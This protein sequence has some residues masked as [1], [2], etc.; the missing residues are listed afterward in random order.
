MNART[1]FLIEPGKPTIVIQRLFD[2]PRRLVF[3][4]STRPEHLASWW[5]PRGSKLTQCKVDLRPGGA[6]RFV[7]RMPDGSEHG[8][9][10]VYKEIVAPSRLVQTFR[11]DGFPDAEALETATFEER[12]EKTLLTVTVLHKSVENRDGHVASGMEEGATESHE[13]LAELLASL[14]ATSGS[15]SAS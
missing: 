11:Y 8:F 10:G 9:G 1:S 5:G 6:W 2:A 4:A 7:L 13:R 14:S 15:S 12:K 3:E